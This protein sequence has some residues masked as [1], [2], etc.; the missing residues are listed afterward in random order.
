MYSNIWYQVVLFFV[1]FALG[2]VCAFVFDAFRVSERFRKSS[3][4]IFAVKD[5]LFWLLITVLMFAICLRFNNGEI[6]FFMFVGIILGAFAYFN[7]LSKFVLRV[8]FFIINWTKK[9]LVFVFKIIFIPVKFVVKLVN[10]P[11][12]IA[13]SFSKKSIKRL[14]KKL[15][16]K[17]KI[18]NK[19]KR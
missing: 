14:F 19:F 16:F 8:L 11:F 12:I 15:K 7:T 9:I 5:I 1:F 6:R 3:T 4:L 18:F 2:I 10:K 17:I 13:F